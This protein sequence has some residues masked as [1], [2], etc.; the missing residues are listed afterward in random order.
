MQEFS[1]MAAPTPLKTSLFRFAS[2]EVDLDR[3]EV[4]RQGIPIPAERKAFDLLVYLIENRNRSIHKNE[5]QQAI[6]EGATVSDA[7][8]TRCVMKARRLVGDDS[9]N[10]TII[11]TIHGHGYRFI[12]EIQPPPA[13]ENSAEGSPSVEAYRQALRIPDRLSI[14][15]LP[16]KDFGDNPDQEYFA[17]GMT[18]DIVTE[19]SRFSSI[20]VTS[21]DSTSRLKD[22]AEEV[23]TLAHKLHVAYIVQGSVRRSDSRVRITV[24][25]TEVTS[26]RRLWSE[27]YDREL[28]ELPI[29]HDDVSRTIAATI[30][31]RA[32]AHRVR[33][34]LDEAGV[35][36]YDLILRAKALHYKIS[37]PSN[38]EA[39][40]LLER[41]LK[42]DPNNPRALVWLASVHGVDGWYRWTKD[43]ERST[44]LA[45]EFGCKAI[46]INDSDATA[47]FVYG[48]VL[49]GQ[50]EYELAES[51]LERA[52]KLNPNDIEI[53]GVYC[54][55]LVSDGRAQEA[56][57]HMA[58]IERLDP[59]GVDWT[60]WTKGVVM[61]G[62]G[63]YEEAIESF[64]QIEGMHMARPWMASAYAKLGDLPKAR[65]SLE[66]FLSMTQDD[67]DSFPAK[68]EQVWRNFLFRELAYRYEKDF[69]NFY[70]GIID[71]GW[72][73]LLDALPDD[74]PCPENWTVQTEK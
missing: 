65:L 60:P 8:L 42:A 16:F 37:K 20:F 35:E 61:F 5:I 36:A 21:P 6:W 1:V 7:A 22:S 57:Q 17:Q 2:C 45:L 18:D 66:K 26:G 29:I 55:L 40:V 73:E 68:D 30:G 23:T 3:R 70:Q 54:G 28:Q 71:A 56:Y 74:L 58:V 4:R 33:Q 46:K 72:L 27:H 24:H 31:G 39:R 12:A 15:V 62:V 64:S 69:Q 14:A 50:C 38:A 63:R 48:E 49:Y 51:H 25:L 13:A 32:E 34:P 19:L 44:R 52:L 9:R 43:P 67:M 59:I 47:H 53:R 10:Q 11:K 41:A